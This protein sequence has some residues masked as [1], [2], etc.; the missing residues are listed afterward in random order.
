MRIKTL[1]IL[2]I[3]LSLRAGTGWAHG[4]CE[5]E[6]AEF[7]PLHEKFFGKVDFLMKHRD[8]L[9]LSEEQTKNIQEKVFEVKRAT[10]DAEA[11]MSIAMLEVYK[12]MHSDN[13]NL[14]KMKSFLDKKIETKRTLSY[15]LLEGLVSV[16]NFLTPEQ[17]VKMKQIFF[18]ERYP[19]PPMETTK[20]V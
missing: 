3:I 14:D 6:H 17:R 8:E 20:P 12:E 1:L 9:S 2:F 4:H 10:I 7:P 11:Q 15:S 13:P 16:R 19:A 18:R 5:R